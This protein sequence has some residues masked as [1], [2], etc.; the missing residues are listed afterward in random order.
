MV[1]Y[2]FL[3]KNFINRVLD[4]RMVLDNGFEPLTFS[5]SRKHSTT[6]LIE[7]Y[8]RFCRILQNK[9]LKTSSFLI[10]KNDILK[11]FNK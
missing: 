9:A 2:D 1:N 10:E 4:V 3:L 11:S 6:E 8:S 7:L 5:L